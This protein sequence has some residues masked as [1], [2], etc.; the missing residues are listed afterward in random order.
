MSD[1]KRPDNRAP[2]TDTTGLSVIPKSLHTEAFYVYQEILRNFCEMC[3]VPFC[4]SIE[5]FAVL[6]RHNARQSP[7]N[8]KIKRRN[9]KEG[10]SRHKKRM[11]NEKW[12]GGKKG[13]QA[14][15]KRQIAVNQSHLTGANS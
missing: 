6:C 1:S 4:I 2:A 9:G 11:V 3:V 12:Q 8:E 13:E 14:E 10:R 15:T 5:E 7:K